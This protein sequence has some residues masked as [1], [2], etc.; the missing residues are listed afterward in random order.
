MY[1]AVLKPFP[2]HQHVYISFMYSVAA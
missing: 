2:L 1:V